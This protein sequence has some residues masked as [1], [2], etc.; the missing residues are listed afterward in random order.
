M[1]LGYG[2]RIADPGFIHHY[3]LREGALTS[4]LCGMGANVQWLFHYCLFVCFCQ[5]SW[6]LTSTNLGTVKQFSNRHYT[7][8]T[9]EQ[10][11]GQFVWFRVTASACLFTSPVDVVWRHCSASATAT[12]PRFVMK[13]FSSFFVFFNTSYVFRRAFI[14]A[15]APPH[16]W[17]KLS[18]INPLTPIVVVPHR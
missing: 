3:N 13:C 17:S 14:S 8:F 9:S 12:T 7:D 11:G 16:G 6:H 4:V 2:F 5:H 15:V 10:N 1:S 18:C